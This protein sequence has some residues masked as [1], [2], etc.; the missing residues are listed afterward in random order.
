MPMVSQLDDYLGVKKDLLKKGGN[1][2]ERVYGVGI[3]DI[4]GRPVYN[5]IYGVF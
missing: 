3:I 5:V 1:L 2:V 4:L